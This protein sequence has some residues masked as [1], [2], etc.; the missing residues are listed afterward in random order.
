[1]DDKG[2]LKRYVN[3]LKHDPEF[4]S[5]YSPF[6]GVS[7]TAK[8]LN[9]TTD[10]IY[11]LSSKG[12]LDLCKCR[13]GRRRFFLRNCVLD[14][15]AGGKLA[16]TKRLTKSERPSRTEVSNCLLR[17]LKQLQKDPHF[18][19]KYGLLLTMELTAA[20]LNID[21][22]S[23]Y[24]WS[25]RGLID[26]CRRKLGRRIQIFRDCLL[27]LIARHGLDTSIRTKDT[28]SELDPSLPHETEYV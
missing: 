7:E 27:A 19:S 22:S 15:L 23:L 5:K 6:L 25:S 14:Q 10:A 4:S 24:E 8:F 11:S 2:D 20:M 28:S 16:R 12:H 17:Y 26:T 21:I 13:V 18:T 1:M 9:V 3:E